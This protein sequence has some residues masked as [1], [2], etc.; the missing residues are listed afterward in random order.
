MGFPNR[1]INY[2]CLRFSEKL[3]M[4]VVELAKTRKLSR[5]TA[6]KMN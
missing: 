5:V 4:R 3:S 6:M 1:S 2:F